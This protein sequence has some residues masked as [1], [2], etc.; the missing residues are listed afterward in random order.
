MVTEILLKPMVIRD[1]EKCWELDQKCFADGEA[2]DIDTLHYLLTSPFLVARKIELS[3]KTIVGFGIG[4]LEPGSVG[5]IIAV[6]VDPLWRRRGF[7]Q[8]LVEALEGGFYEQGATVVRLEVRVGN[9]AAQHLYRKLGYS[10]TQRLPHY[11]T[12]GDDAYL[13]TKALKREEPLWNLY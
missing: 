6:G 13:M 4:M 9:I 11:Y 8:M 7:G 1:L 5:H 3:G 12:N 2:Y 10:I